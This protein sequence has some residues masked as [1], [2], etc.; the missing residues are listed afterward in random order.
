MHIHVH[1]HTRIWNDLELCVILCKYI[2]ACTH[3]LVCFSL[4][5]FL[6][7][8]ITYFF[9]DSANKITFQEI[10]WTEDNPAWQT[11]QKK[12]TTKTLTLVA[13]MAIMVILTRRF[14]YLDVCV[15]VVFCFFINAHVLSDS[16]VPSSSVLILR[17]DQR[18]GWSTFNFQYS[19]TVYKVWKKILKFE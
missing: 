4:S 18:S 6:C 10:L 8:L 12:S 14:T 19:Y 3:L 17:K 16:V 1:V 7:F 5:L 15:C 9:H 2:H 13:C 11:L